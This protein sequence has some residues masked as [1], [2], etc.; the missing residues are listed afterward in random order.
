MTDKPLLSTPKVA[1][2]KAGTYDSEIIA[3]AIEKIFS[4]LGGIEKFVTRGDPS[5]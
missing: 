2:V 5:S 1:L 4:L 3:A